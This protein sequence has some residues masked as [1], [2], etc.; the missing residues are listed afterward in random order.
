MNKGYEI[1]IKILER[2]MGKRGSRVIFCLILIIHGIKHSDLLDKYG[3]ALSTTRKYK[4]VL[5]MGNVDSLFTVA[6]RERMKS[7][8]DDFET[9][10]LEDF[11]DNP[12]KTLREA[13]SR[14]EIPA[15]PLH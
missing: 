13:Q 4:R 3:Y 1:I 9:E 8:L 6:E 12:P 2:Y 15:Y 10:I 11:E 7:K 5:E 14:I